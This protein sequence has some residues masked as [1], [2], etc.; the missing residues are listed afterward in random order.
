MNDI[1]QA[2][3]PIL[4]PMVLGKEIAVSV[5]DQQVLATWVTLKVVIGEI[6]RAE[7]AVV[8]PAL[9]QWFRANRM[10]FYD[11]QIYVL[12][13][14]MG[15]PR[16]S[17]QHSSFSFTDNP[18]SIS[19]PTVQYSWLQLGRVLFVFVMS[20]HFF[21]QF[22]F[23]RTFSHRADRIFPPMRS[24]FQWPPPYSLEEAQNEEFI[25]SFHQWLYC[26]GIDTNAIMQQLRGSRA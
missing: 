12:H 9:R 5:R 26:L 25:N 11:S 2:V 14:A 13:D 20:P 3:I 10:P 1:E 19:P 17:F 16:R 8:T 22:K 23:P 15:D 4:T 7:S 24:A 18:E 21:P 6:P